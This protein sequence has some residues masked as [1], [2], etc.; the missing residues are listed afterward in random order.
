MPLS[1]LQP[2][3]VYSACRALYNKQHKFGQINLEISLQFKLDFDQDFTSIINCKEQLKI[4]ILFVN[5]LI[6]ILLHCLCIFFVAIVNRIYINQ[7]VYVKL[8][9]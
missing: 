5:Y 9:G 7:S 4:I 6:N 1:Q 2:V 8:F 3:S